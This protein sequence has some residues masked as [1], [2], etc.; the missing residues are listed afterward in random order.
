MD[1][2]ERL[3]TL[4]S[5]IGEKYNSDMYLFVNTIND[6]TSD[7]FINLVRDNPNRRPGCLLI[8][9]TFGGDPNA[10]YRIA[11]AIKHY[12]QGGFTLFV[13]GSCKSTGTLI[14]LAADKI[15]MSDFGEFGP[16]DI[17]LTKDDELQNTSGLS[18]LQSLT[19]LTEQIFRSFEK[20]FLSLKQRSGNTITTRTA[21]E[22]ASKLAVGLI[23]PISGQL[24][25]VKLG[26]VNRAINIADAYGNRLTQEKGTV[27]K[28]ITDYPSHGFVID[29]E[30]AKEIFKNVEFVGQDE[31]ALERLLLH[32]IRKEDR[33]GVII[34]NLTDQFVVK[35]AGP[36]SENKEPVDA[37]N[38]NSDNHNGKQ[39]A[40]RRKTT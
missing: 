27:R 4:I 31:A 35:N 16:L 11:R 9:T 29:Y 22:V 30:E 15:I 5:S 28:L 3:R 20:N 37:T 21:A 25:P 39:R 23:S 40:T 1:H 8:L 33:G 18:Y 10:G 26:E 36:A 13:F 19:S 12:Y 38:A 14:A 17:Q 24:D 34:T 32:M 7:T 6:E 2:E